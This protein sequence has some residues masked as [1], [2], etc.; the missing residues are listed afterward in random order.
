[1]AE[2]GFSV[3]VH[4][5]DEDVKHF[6]LSSDVTVGEARA[7]VCKEFEYAEEAKFTLYRVDAFEEPSYALRRA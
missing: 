1:M 7:A 5:K 6:F 2:I 3:I 4:K